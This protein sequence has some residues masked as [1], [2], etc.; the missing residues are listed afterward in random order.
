MAARAG[1]AKAV[2]PSAAAAIPAPVRI[3]RRD[4]DVT[5]LAF[6]ASPGS[7]GSLPMASSLPSRLCGV[8]LANRPAMSASCQWPGFRQCLQGFAQ[9]LDQGC[10]R[11]QYLQ[12]VTGE[13][14]GE[15]VRELLGASRLFG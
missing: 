9:A 13:P 15:D 11:H 4:R 3:C 10:R 1:P 12:F 8:T 5:W 14:A 6:P 7:T 2:V